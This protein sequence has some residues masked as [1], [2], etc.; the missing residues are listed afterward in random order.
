MDDSPA[1]RVQKVERTPTYLKIKSAQVEY[2]REGEAPVRQQA[3]YIDRPNSVGVLVYHRDKKLF[4]WVEQCRVG[5][6]V[7]EP[8]LA[9]TIEPVAGMCD[10]DDRAPEQA[11]L[12]ETLEET[13][14]QV[15]TLHPMASFYMCSGISNEK[16][17][18]FIAEVEHQPL[19]EYAGLAS[20]NEHIRLHHWTAQE[21]RAAF[22]AGRFQTAQSLLLWQ[23]ACMKF[24][25]WMTPP[26][27][28]S[29]LTL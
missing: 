26:S 21:S 11:A 28:D 24:G 22:E 25:H 4:T 5:V 27:Q 12:R 9:F 7:K 15:H 10:P 29:G 17:S 6:A 20:E 8:A 13:G 19:L 18:L 16:M 14:C 1:L 2:Q 23:F 3:E